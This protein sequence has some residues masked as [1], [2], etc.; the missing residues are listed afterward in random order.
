MDDRAAIE[1]SHPSDL[2]HG[3]LVVVAAFLVALFGFGLGFYGPGIYLVALKA[4]HGWSIEEL[5]SVITTYYVLG[6]SL[7]FFGVGSL[8]ERYGARKVL[9]VGIVAMSM[10]LVL[11]TRVARLWQVYA[12]FVLMSVGW[13]TMSGAAINI[14]VAPWFERR[15]GL[16]VSWALNGASAGGVIIAPVLTFLATRYSFGLALGALV[17]SM[18]AIL[19]PVVLLVLRPRHADECD[20]PDRDVAGPRIVTSPAEAEPFHLASVLCSGRFISISVPFAL[21]LTA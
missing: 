11:L 14:I 5:S 8:F 21:G 16:A 4:R 19:M 10:G 7:L 6:A 13:A 2:Y 12:A 3:W 9:S 17:G 18:L 15:R 1:R 20:P